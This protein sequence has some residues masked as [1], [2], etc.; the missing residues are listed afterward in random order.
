MPVR[1]A[2]IH[3]FRRNTRRTALLAGAS[4]VAFFSANPE[5]LAKPIGNWSAAPSAAAIAAAQSG[6]QEAARAARDANNALE[7]GDA[8]DPGDAV[9]AARRRAMRQGQR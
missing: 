8:G 4:A 6:S 1:P 5:A 9:D 3:S 7:A 2:R